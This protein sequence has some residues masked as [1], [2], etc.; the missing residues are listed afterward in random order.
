M[1]PTGL[2]TG[3]LTNTRYSGSS[4]ITLPP[5]TRNV[6]QG[7]TRVLL[8]EDQHSQDKFGFR[9]E[10]PVIENNFPKQ[11]PNKSETHP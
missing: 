2:G 3:I 8:N 7:V 11:T 9:N 1:N 5:F 6:I 4:I 10:F